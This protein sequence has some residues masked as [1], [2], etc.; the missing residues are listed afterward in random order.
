MRQEQAPK[1]LVH[2][3]VCGSACK[4][5][6]WCGWCVSFSS[7]YYG[8]TFILNDYRYATRSLAIVIPLVGVTWV[9][10]VFSISKELV[11]FQYIFVL[12]NTLQVSIYLS[13]YLSISFFLYFRLS[14]FPYVINLKSNK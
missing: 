10:G 13:I 6:I 3:R 2:V 7:L 9:L 4:N 8:F 14:V 1:H 12:L 11:V 5:H